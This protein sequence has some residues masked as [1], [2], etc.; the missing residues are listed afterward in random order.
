MS[1]FIIAEAGVNHNGS[2][3]MAYQLIKVAKKAGVDAIKF[4]TFVPELLVTAD[5]PRAIYQQRN[6]PDKVE[7]QLE[8]LQRYALPWEV[9]VRLKKCCDDE[10]VL[11]LSTP[12]DETSADFLDPLMPLYKIASGDAVNDL[13]LRHIARKGKP[14]IV[15][16]GMCSLDE[17]MHCKEVIKDIDPTLA[18]TLLHCTTDYPCSYMNVHL[19]AMLTMKEAL[20]LPVGYSDHTPG[21]EVSIAAV[22]LGATVIEKHFTLDRTL[23]GPDHKASLE[24]DELGQL[25]KSIRHIEAALGSSEKTPATVENEARKLVRKSLVTKYDLEEGTFLLEAHLLTKR[26]GIGIAPADLSQVVGRQ[27]KHSLLSDH[28]LGWSDLI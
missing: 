16:T 5:A 13:F 28:V 21:I 9:F 11:F 27:L 2:Q 4:Q 7:S 14:I 23:P 1:V 22:A 6:M 25:V 15:S 8:M 17:V 12:F 18:L 20:N 26:P 10:G 19:K 24:P 3:E